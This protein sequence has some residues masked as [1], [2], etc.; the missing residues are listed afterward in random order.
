[1]IPKNCSIFNST[2]Y[3]DPF[4]AYKVHLEK[5][6]KE[7]SLLNRIKKEICSIFDISIQSEYE[8]KLLSY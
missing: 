5:L 8:R 1:M 2:I 3:F 4:V 6:R 7:Y